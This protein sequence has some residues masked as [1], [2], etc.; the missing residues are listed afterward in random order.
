MRDS[1][2]RVVI[3]GVGTVNPL[4][5]TLSETLAAMAA[6][7]VAIG[8][9]EIDAS[10][11]VSVTLGAPVVGWQAEAHF[12]PEELAM[13]DRFAQFAVVS[14]QKAAEQ[15]GLTLTQAER[16]RAGVIIGTGAGGFSTID[17]AY[18]AVFRDGKRRVHPFTVPRLMPHA[19][20]GQIARHLGLEGPAL[21][22]STACASGTHALGL[23]MQWLRAGL[24]DVML[25]GGAEATLCFGGVKA[26]EA[27]RVLSPDGCRPFCLTRNGMVLGEGAAVFVLEPLARAKARGAPILAEIAGF[28]MSADAGDMV[29]PDPL[30]AERAMRAA[31]EDAAL[32][33]AAV[34]YINAHG[35][36]TRLNDASEA[37][38]IKAV[39]GSKPPPV[40]STKSM[41]GHLLGAAGAVEALA[42]LLALSEG[43]IA[44]TVGFRAEDPACALDLVVNEARAAAVEVALSNSFAFGGTNACL[45]L[46]RV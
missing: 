9:L 24:V 37:Q 5:T 42:C 40:S 26:W 4:G 46:R 41:H 23:A 10:A 31:L 19:A 32:P 44:P 20:A 2:R 27:L 30:G 18:R 45:V 16:A 43:L 6:G 39:F 17:A 29:Q 8:P 7:K 14:A 1:V 38:A 15:A 3:T 33:P 11:P 13:L 21:T 22:V 28:G 34:D 25:A 35:T 12:P 36:G